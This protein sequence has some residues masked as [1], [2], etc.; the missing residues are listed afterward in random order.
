M[1]PAQTASPPESAW[2]VRARRLGPP[3]L[4]VLGIVTVFWKLVLTDQYTF[5]ESPDMANQVMPWLQA[6]VYAIR[7]WSVLLWDP[8]EWNG[9]SLIGQ[10]QPGTASP[11]TFLL[12]L[13]PVN[14]AQIQVYWVHVWFVLIHCCAGLFAYWLLV[15]LGCA[16]GAAVL[17]GI[18]YATAGFV[19]NTE[20]PQHL[21]AGIWAPLVFLFLFRL[22]RG[23]SP[24]KSAAWCGVSLGAAWL[25]GHHAPALAL[26]L[27]AA[28]VALW[29]AIT[30]WKTEARS[31]A[32]ALAR[33]LALVFVVAGLVSAVQTIPAY[34]YG[35]LA[36]RWTATGALTWKDKVEIPEHMDSGLSPTD[37][38]HVAMPGGEGLRS[39]PFVGVIG[40]S[41]AAI[42]L[43]G[44]FE[45]REVRL[46]VAVGIGA[47]LYAMSRYDVLYG[48]FYAL[49]PGVEKSRAP[50]VALSVFHFAI[51]ALVGIGADLLLRAPHM[52]RESKLLRVL[53]WAGAV[54]FG[55]FLLM[56]YLKPGITS[57]VLDGD[58][59]LGMIGLIA[60]LAAGLFHIWNR[61]YVGGTLALALLGLLLI[62]EQGNEVGHGWVQKHDAQRAV[63]L[64]ALYDTADLAEWLHWQPE[65]KRVDINDDDPLLKFTFGDWYRLETVHAFTASMLTAT[66]EL[67][68]WQDRM[69]RFYGINYLVGR[70]PTRD[71]QP[72]VF[73]GKSGIKIFANPD[74]FPRAWTVHRTVTAPDEQKTWEMVRDGPTDLR[75]AVIMPGAAPE[76]LDTCTAADQVGLA[77]ERPSSVAVD[78]NMACK[79]L[80]VVSDNWYPGWHA[81]VDGKSAGL[82][83]VDGAVRGVVVPRGW[84]RVTMTYRPFSVY[85]GLLLTALGLAIAVV[86]GRRK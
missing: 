37:L 68:W 40:L 30:A 6:Q 84:H 42:A 1:N 47:L 7:H 12:A 29:V 4:V 53:V 73:A 26:S 43:W 2:R 9:Q 23:R 65:P 25:C 36:K 57:M 49:V 15:D 17:G 8:Y 85:F 56:V 86:L 41:L 61:G 27:A 13:A 38:L 82:W 51:A 60:L 67:G 64:K 74:A 46:L 76:G 21:A 75:T 35:K 58:P 66:S 59:R 34:E 11:F 19:G 83:K 44:A 24:R 52:A 20:W 16:A 54:T 14:H 63:L 32:L 22:L 69:V 72:E 10:V 45:R 31:A 70:K 80:L 28:G 5:L 81:Y 18:F 50:I 77:R 79:G 62:V 3:L 78:V 48:L 71:G 55:M 33:N 39:D